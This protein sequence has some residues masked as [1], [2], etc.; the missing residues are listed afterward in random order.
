MDLMGLEGLEP[1]VPVKGKPALK[2]KLTQ[3]NIMNCWESTKKPQLKK[4]GKPS[5]KKP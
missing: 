5:E 1:K 4:S 3:T 2:N